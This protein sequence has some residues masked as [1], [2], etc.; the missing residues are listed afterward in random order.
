MREGAA[1]PTPRL[2][3]GE[4]TRG[5]NLGNVPPFSSTTLTAAA[6]TFTRI[7]VQ[8]LPRKFLRRRALQGC[9]PRVVLIDAR[10]PR[11]ALETGRDGRRCAATHRRLW[12]SCPEG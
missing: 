8:R 10:L 7:D 4:E 9:G 11:R 3:F 6:G 2:K 1:R 12:Q 5:N